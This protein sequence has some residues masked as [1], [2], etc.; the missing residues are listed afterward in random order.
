MV[1]RGHLAQSEWV[2]RAVSE[3]TRWRVLPGSRELAAGDF[4]WR[5]RLVCALLG[6]HVPVL[7]AIG[8]DREGAAGRGVLDAALPL[9]LLLLAVAPLP[10]R[11]RACS[12][13][14]GLVSCSALLVHLFPAQP[15]L[16]VHYFVAV[17]AVA[18]YQDWLAYAV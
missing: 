6:L 7:L 3:W 14:I 10:R 4:R 18:L 9:G 16:H 1:P 17:A 13:T 5:H 15:E 12:A 2:T 11:L 8:L